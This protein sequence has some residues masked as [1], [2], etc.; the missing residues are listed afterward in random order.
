[1]MGHKACWVGFYYWVAWKDVAVWFCCCTSILCVALR[2]LSCL[3]MY[4]C[5]LSP[6][7]RTDQSVVYLIF[8]YIQCL[9]LVV[10][11]FSSHFL[12]QIV[13]TLNAVLVTLLTDP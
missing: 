7:N 4:E 2:C 11:C 8:H 6:D 5:I 13:K 3:S 9:T 12:K 10:F 1:M